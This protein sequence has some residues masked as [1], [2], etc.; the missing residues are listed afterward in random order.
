MT[1]SVVIIKT[2]HLFLIK[3]TNHWVHTVWNRIIRTFSTI[4]TCFSH[5]SSRSTPHSSLPS[6]LLPPS[7]THSLLPPFPTRHSSL[8]SSLVT[9]P[10]LP[11]S[12]LF[13][14][15]LTRHSSLP[16]SL[17]T[18]P[19]LPHSSHF[20]SFL[21]RQSSLTP[22]LPLYNAVY[23][24][25]AKKSFTGY[26]RSLQLLPGKLQQDV[27]KLPLDAFAISLGLGMTPEA[28]VAPQGAEEREGVREKKNV[29]R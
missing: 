12:S 19:F 15:F 27:T 26:L 23:H 18:L 2:F 16:S 1:L 10:F 24:R 21:T 22:Y 9:L 14:S 20:P 17:V 29:N 6:S 3:Q 7:L 13:P 5:P 8:P 4:S 25:L 28:P 11:H